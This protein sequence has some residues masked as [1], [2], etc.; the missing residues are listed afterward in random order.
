MIKQK[1][2]TFILSNWKELLV[3]VCL[4]AV[5]LKTRMDHRAITKAYD[6]SR[7]E[8][9]LQIQSLKD[10]HA[11]EIKLREEALQS[12]RDTIDKIEKNYLLSQEALKT[13]QQEKAVRFEKQ[14]SEDKE[15]LSEE[16][17]NTFDFEYVE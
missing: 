6:V 5:V 16:I 8:M 1:I 11:E 17:I 15:A 14:F 12:Y 10:I 2:V 4:M 13:E 9:Q 3:I 7:Q